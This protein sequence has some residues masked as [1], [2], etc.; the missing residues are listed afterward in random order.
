[1]RG[2][3]HKILDLENSIERNILITM[4]M[5][6]EFLKKIVRIIDVSLFA[7]EVAGQVAQWV[8]EYY[9]R[10]GSAPS[11]AMEGIFEAH[12]PTLN[13][14]DSQWVAMF[15]IS[16]NKQYVEGSE[17]ELSTNEAYLFDRTITHFKKRQLYVNSHKVLKLLEVD[18]VAEAETIWNS[19]MKAPV[20]M[21]DLGMDPFDPEVIFKL[22]AVGMRF[23]MSLGIKP[24]DIL[25]GP[26][27]S[28]WLIMTMAPMKRGKTQ[29]LT[30][31]ALRAKLLG[32][33][34]VYISLESGYE[35]MI[36]RILM[37]AGSM[38]SSGNGKVEFPMF[39]KVGGIYYEEQQ[40]PSVQDTGSVLEVI[41]RFKR[42]AMGQAIMKSFPSYTAGL[43]EIK[44]YLDT[45]EIMAGFVPHVICVDYLGA[46]KP[47]K[48]PFG[49]DIYDVNAKGL[50]SLSEERKC[51][52]FSAHQGSR[53][54]LDK[55]NM[56]PSDIP[57]DVRI[58]GHVDVLYGLNQT[59]EEKKANVMR[60]NVLMHRFRRFNRFKQAK[61]LQQPEAGQ[62]CIDAEPCD[63]PMPKDD[64]KPSM[65]RGKA[66]EENDAD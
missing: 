55:M 34:V 23:S 45:L 52:V 16:L 12:Q 47:P 33:N 31:C 20:V 37:A 18:R 8:L 9:E 42:L 66:N 25:A 19:T 29:F 1:M 36:N 2:V 64:Y 22:R 5:S 54:T 21:E 50:K 57:E 39:D 3:T 43:T 56:N 44:R 41:Y 40:R 58:L 14:V 38:V 15:L 13:E 59:E 65:R 17:G 28:E 11:K 26:Q 62:F 6:T 60:M 24:L 51:I 35:D 46:M 4:I 10:Y 61:I 53:R 49:R 63:A 27:L 48:G 30:H 32:M 7:T